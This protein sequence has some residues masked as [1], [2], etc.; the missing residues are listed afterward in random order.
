MALFKHHLDNK[1]YI[2]NILVLKFRS[3]MITFKIIVFLKMFAKK[4]FLFRVSIE[5]DGSGCGLVKRIQPK[6]N[7]ETCW[8]MFDH[9]K[10]VGW[11][12][13]T[14]HMY[15]PIYYKMMTIVMCDMQSKDIEV[16]SEMWWKLNKVIAK[17]GVP[18]PN[19]MANGAQ[20]KLEHGTNCV[21]LR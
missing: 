11:M 10:H 21:W 16:Q 3:V 18:N 1:G 6:G 14:S 7:L 5:G 8:F 17:K 12:G 15:D 9:I 2:D 20:A 13:P 19:F 4:M